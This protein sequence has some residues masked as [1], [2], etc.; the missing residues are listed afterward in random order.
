MTRKALIIDGGCAYHGN[1]GTL[2][3]HFAQKTKEVLTSLCWEVSVTEGEKDWDAAAEAAKVKAAD[4]VILQ[5]P[6]W[7]MAPP[8]QVKRYEDEVFCQPV[9]APNDGRT[10][11]DPEHNYGHGGTLTGGYMISCTWNAPHTAFTDPKEFFEG[12]GIDGEMIAVHKTFQ[13]IG[14]KQAAPTFMANDVIKNPKIA[15]DEARLVA[16]LKKYFA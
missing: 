16:Q 5:T 12:K 8:W 13:F 7:W 3:H 4:L 6:A 2:N 14:L 9:I 11:T 10:H 1:G 15:E